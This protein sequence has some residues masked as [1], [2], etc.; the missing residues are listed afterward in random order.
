MLGERPPGCGLGPRVA[1][2]AQDVAVIQLARERCMQLRT[3]GGRLLAVAERG[4]RLLD[5]G[6][7]IIRGHARR[8]TEPVHEQRD[9]TAQPRSRELTR[10]DQAAHERFDRGTSLGAEDLGGEAERDTYD[11]VDTVDATARHRTCEN[12]Q[13]SGQTSRESYYR[14]RDLVVGDDADRLQHLA[15]RLRAEPLQQDHRCGAAQPLDRPPVTRGH[16]HE[17]RPKAQL[18]DDERKKIERNIVDD[19][20]V[21]DDQHDRLAFG[22]PGENGRDVLEHPRA[23]VTGAQQI[24]QLLITTERTD[25]RGPGP[26]PRTVAD[27]AAGHPQQ[28]HRCVRCFGGE[29]LRER[30]LARTALAEQHPGPAVAE[31]QRVELCCQRCELGVSA[32]QRHGHG[33]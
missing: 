7:P 3:Q 4:Q 30:G 17:E 2:L 25:D 28:P 22:F 18:L 14:R 33:D 20:A 5:R 1:A 19:V 11:I 23:P 15:P 31:T 29:R 10:R 32:D 13:L 26:A 9:L 24:D 21:V 12:D 6:D 16:E 8:T 27:R